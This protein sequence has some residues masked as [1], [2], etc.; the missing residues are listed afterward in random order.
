MKM[1]HTLGRVIYLIL[2]LFFLSIAVNSREITLLDGKTV[3]LPEETKKVA[4][5]YG[6]SFEKV[7]LLGAESKIVLCS[8]FHRQF[9]WPNVVCERL[10][11]IP[12]TN[13]FLSPN[14][15]SLLKNK[16]DVVFFW[17]KPDFIK[18][19]NDVG[20]AVV[21][22]SGIIGKCLN[23]SKR[24]LKIYADA[25]GKREEKVAEEYCA[26]F[27]EKLKIVTDVTSKIQEE[28]RTNV[29]F[30]VRKLLSTGGKNSIIPD[31]VEAAGGNCLTKNINLNYGGM[32]SVEQFLAWN[33]DFIVIDHCGAE[34]MGS[35]PAKKIAT[36]IFEDY[37][38]KSVKAV[39][40]KKVFISPTGVFFWD[41]G[42]QVILQIMWLA[43]ILHP[44]KFQHINLENELKFFYSKFFR[45]HLTDEEAQRI[46][47]H[48]SPNC[49]DIDRN[50]N[51][52]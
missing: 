9:P 38:L 44:D 50:D 23:D 31:I 40:N 10:K 14:I 27:D 26:Y 24:L 8:V 34:W 49:I 4:C 15:E 22:P 18:K 25:L 39:K 19:L 16:P 1:H 43:K 7:L 2:L 17:N 20:I 41:S 29:Y 3:T 42:Q 35:A 21:Y 11:N 32:I 47:N 13:S 48:Q 51:N 6:P 12:V 36:R 5:L 37:R 52:L 46:L 33:P 28:K 45:Y 30:A